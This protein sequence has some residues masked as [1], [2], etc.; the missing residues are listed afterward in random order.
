MLCLPFHRIC[1]FFPQG[2]AFDDKRLDLVDMGNKRLMGNATV[3]EEW[4]TSN[5]ATSP[6]RS[7]LSI[8]SCGILQVPPISYL[9]NNKSYYVIDIVSL[10][11]TR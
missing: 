6:T 1:V 11:T 4:K 7:I 2:L 5:S 8:V 10:K 9:Y 3:R